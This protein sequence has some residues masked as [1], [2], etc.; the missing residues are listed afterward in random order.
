MHNP[1]T[2]TC[3]ICGRRRPFKFISMSEKG[4]QYCNDNNRGTECHL[5]VES[6]A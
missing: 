6:H 4:V 5:K 3:D 2:L 1:K